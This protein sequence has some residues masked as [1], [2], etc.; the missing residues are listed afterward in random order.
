METMTDTTIDTTPATAKDFLMKHIN[1]FEDIAP[2][3]GALVSKILG[4]GWSFHFNRR[5][6]RIL[7]I[8]RPAQRRIE[9]SYNFAKNYLAVDKGEVVT[10]ILHEVAHAFAYMLDPK[11]AREDGGH[12]ATWQRFC[13][14]LGIAGEKATSRLQNGGGCFRWALVNSETG[15]VYRKWFKRPHRDFSCCIVGGDMSTLGKLKVVPLQ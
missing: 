11:T 13:A 1:S 5:T 6:S 3:S 14:L 15:K 4:N 2:V 12:G 9:L 10:T 7:G 8:C